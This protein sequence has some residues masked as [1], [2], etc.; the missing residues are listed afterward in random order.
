MTGHKENIQFRILSAIGIILV[1]AGHLG[2]YPFDIGGLFPYYSFHVFIF[3]FI[4]GYFY[5]EEAQEHIGAYILKK[6]KT[7]LLPYFAW[8]LFYG[9]VTMLLHRAGFSIGQDISLYTLLLAPFEG[10]HHFMYHFPAWFVPVLFIIE[11]INILMRKVLHLLRLNKEWLIFTGCLIVGIV[12]VALAISGRVWG[13]Y[14]IP[15]RILFMLP[16]FQMGCFYRAKLQ[17]YDTLS[18]KIY[19]PMVLGVQLLITF[20]NG[21]LAFSAVWVSGFANGPIVPYLTIITG[22]AFWL[23]IA[24]ILSKVQGISDGLVQ[25]GRH[26][27]S[28]IMHHMFIFFGINSL[29]WILSRYTDLCPEFNKELYFSDINYVYIASVSDAGKWI[30]LVAGV[31]LPVL[32]SKYLKKKIP[33]QLIHKKKD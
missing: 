1:V 16:G 24:R 19:F 27:F 28:V 11:V 23:R 3:L 10:G 7:L 20:L 12:V 4:S 6:C 31:M 15:G 8:N 13:Y 2:F 5:K 9:L 25:I 18:D 26:T 33:I 32:L 22:I 30:Y 29:F 21:G 14:K 17:K